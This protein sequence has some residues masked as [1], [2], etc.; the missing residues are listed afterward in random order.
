[1]RNLFPK[2]FLVTWIAIGA[3]YAGALRAQVAD[4]V[5]VN[6]VS[7]IPGLATITDPQLVNPWGVS[8]ST[9]SPF[10]TSNQGA[11][12]ATLYAVTDKTTVSKTNINPPAGFVRSRQRQPERRASKDRPARSTIPTL[13]RSGGEWRRRWFRALH[14]RQFERNHFGL[15]HGDD[16]LYPGHD[17]RG[18]LHRVGDQRRTNAPLCRQ[19]CGDRQRRRIRQHLR[20]GEPRG[21]RIR[22]PRAARRA[23]PVQ[24]A[25]DRRQR[26]RDLCARRARPTRPAPRWAQ[27]P[28]RFSMKTATS[29]RN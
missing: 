21:R 24:R 12:T 18:R 8:H 6:L 15:G 10:W 9:T 4:F 13:R 5:Q 29:S 20:P 14:L 3:L 26:L 19:R 23:R 16:G 25:G 22:R 1:M 17:P 28:W 27:G 7:D 11:N 2:T